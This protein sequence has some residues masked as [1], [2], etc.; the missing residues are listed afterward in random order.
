MG[1]RE[2]GWLRLADG[3]EKEARDIFANAAL[4]MF[5]RIS[6]RDD[7]SL[8]SGSPLASGHYSAS[9]RLGINAS[10]ATVARVDANYD[11][12]KPSVHLY[13]V[14]LLPPPTIPG[15]KRGY[16]KAALAAFKLGDRVHI[17]SS[18]DYAIIIEDGRIGKTGSWQKPIGVFLPT[19]D[20]LFQ[21]KGWY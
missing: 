10:D 14:G 1:L 11:Y 17:S 19:L 16:A 21:Q 3:V 18:V 8:G 6:D 12:P 4:V 13:K 2:N 15:V 7:T 9:M 5:E 20:K